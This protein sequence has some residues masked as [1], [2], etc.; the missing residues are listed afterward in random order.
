M[1]KENHPVE[2]GGL[3]APPAAEDE[4]V[5]ADRPPAER[6]ARLREFATRNLAPAAAKILREFV[7]RL[8]LRGA[9]ETVRRLARRLAPS[10][11]KIVGGLVSLSLFL[12]AGFIL[13]RVFSSIHFSDLRAAM[14][15]TSAGQLLGALPFAALSYVA[16]TGYDA[17]A[18]R[19][20]GVRVPYRVTS[21]ASFAS[22]A[23]SFNLGFPLVTSAA[24]RFWVYSRVGLTALEVANITVI[25]GVTFWLG[26]TAAVGAGLAARAGEIAAIDRLPAFLNWILGVL[27]LA[28]VLAYIVW[29][30]LSRRCVRLR[31]RLFELPGFGLTI[32]Q[33]VLGVV[34]L[35]C[36]AGSLYALLPAHDGL[37]FFTFVSIYVFA[38]ILG[39]V[40]HA[41][42]G[43]GVFEATMLH[44]LPAHSQESILA[45][46]VLFRLIYYFAPFLLALALLGADEGARRWGSLR[47]AISKIIEDRSE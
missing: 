5:A 28:G 23:F 11:A 13:V 3:S 26:M 9:G 22:Y 21:L 37:D 1:R 47:E 41:P 36:A 2:I 33:M 24:V 8:A 43:I 19:Q 27:V 17:L 38:C 46:L 29:V 34:D 14:A 20:L 32:G 6:A 45:P 7:Q 18:L 31:G 42:G 30:S 16:L 39:I 40:S 25:A 15:A 12:L 10:A 4:A 35:C 44:A